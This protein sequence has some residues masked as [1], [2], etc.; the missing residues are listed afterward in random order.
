MITVNTRDE[1]LKEV[2]GYLPQNCYAVEIG[3]LLGDFSEEILKIINPCVL[4]LVDPYMR[5]EIRYGEGFGWMTTAYSTED[6][7]QELLKRFKNE[8]EEIRVIVDRDFSYNV[9]KRVR[10]K[11][12]DFIYLDASHLYKDVKRDLND[13]LPKLKENGI[14]CGD[15][16]IEFDDFGVIQAVNEFIQEHNFE[17][18]IFNT[19]G[20]DWAL[21]RK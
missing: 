11:Y 20:G 9:V 18:I 19:N 16:Y 10:E 3:V 6:E 14:M 13:W 2:K 7:Y 12:F 8:I 1:F 21:K 15:D 17:M 4:I 5:C